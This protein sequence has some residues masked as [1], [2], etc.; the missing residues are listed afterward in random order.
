MSPDANMNPSE[1][2]PD[3]S[4]AVSPDAAGVLLLHRF[5][6]CAAS[7]PDA[8]AVEFR[9][10]QLTYA[11]LN[12]RANQVAHLLIDRGVIP[13]DLIA[14]CL[15]ASA[16]AIVAMLAVLKAGA[17]YVPID[18]RWPA[19]RVSG[20]VDQAGPKLVLTSQE[21]AASLCALIPQPVCIEALLA[22]A[23]ADAVS[24]DNPDVALNGNALCYVIYTSGTTG[25]P[26]GVMVS[27]KNIANLFSSLQEELHFSSRD[28]W[29]GLHSFAFGYSVW[30]IWGAL[31]S[32]AGLVIVP[33]DMRRDPGAWTQLAAA[34]G[35]SVLSLTPSALRQLLNL[36]PF[37]ADAMRRLVRLVVLS[38]EALEERDL[39][40]WF[41]HFSQTGPRLVNTFALTETAGR[42]ATSEYHQGKRP[43]ANS[44]GMPTQDAELFVVDPENLELSAE[45]E[46][47]VAGPM[48]AAG[49]LGNPELSA[50]RF[51]RF[52]P[53]DGRPRYCYRTGDVVRR[54]DS[55][56][57]QFAGR[58]DMQVKLR[59]HRVELSDIEH[60]LGRHPQIADAA[61]II[62]E[63]LS[64]TGRLSAFIVFKPDAQPAV[65]FWPS[66][67]EHLLY[68]ELLYDFMSA[69]EVR[70]EHYRAA[71]A[72]SV[73][74]KVVLDIGTG[75][76]AVLARM[77]A[78]AGARKVYAVELLEDACQ[79][80]RE[81]VADL[82]L[83]GQIEV[84][85]GD[86]QTVELPEQVD[87]CTQGVVGNIGSSDG[88]VPLWNA[89]RRWF[90]DD[91]AA[92]PARCTTLIAP[93]EL[94]A[95]VA[96]EPA[97]TSLA[98]DYLKRLFAEAGREFDARL[99]VR[100]F[101]AGNLLTDA[102]VF[103]ELD[104]GAGL[105]A[106]H[107]G[108]AEVPVH[109]QG[110]FDGFLL[111]T[112]L[113]NPGIEPVDFLEHQQAWLP[114]WLPVEDVGVPVE[115]GDRIAIDW[116][117]TTPD[118]SIFPD[119]MI[120]ADVYGAD[121]DSVHLSFSSPHQPTGVGQTTLHRAL[122]ANAPLAA[123]T[124]GADALRDWLSQEIPAYMVPASI[125]PIDRLPLNTSAKL[126]R[127]KL[128]QL[129]AAAV[130]RSPAEV[131]TA[132]DSFEAAIAEIWHSVL[133]RRMGRNED[134]FSSG[135]DS[136]LAVR[137]T[138]EIQRYLDDTIF[139]AALF[140]APTI[141]EYAQW[142]RAYHAEAV[143]RCVNATD[144]WE[145]GEL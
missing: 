61:V 141:A 134:F 87:V 60:A 45:G 98:A 12:A 3:V 129:A 10:G 101:P 21:N 86:M 105:V 40:Q 117:V 139:L 34:A 50:E 119:Y 54:L 114:V 37:P 133:G 57:L 69:D 110:R 115:P 22:A 120:S 84:I 5:E 8:L 70:I 15:S 14:L 36:E 64:G 83:D 18:A 55:G 81:L 52:D 106:A 125:Q 71:F 11:Q 43:A 137:L 58:M 93:G 126:D 131:E 30:E 9:G 132:D 42:I 75:R 33:E 123:S 99:C 38:G 19:G 122:Y 109:R 136:I 128:R 59:G 102:T 53:G 118:D 68:D 48:V 20:A 66:L 23:T 62:D 104:F 67:G 107:S 44:I 100:N 32:G 130:A 79:S 95:A 92:I 143:A 73:A 76:H 51:I 24:A 89:A 28:R 17:A 85:C 1:V 74:G 31:S 35:V 49:Y 80:A 142:L 113:S 145:E 16:D 127:D 144:D 94:P 29:L 41:E 108:R 6:A 91:F 96:G 111:W 65:E 90:N 103:E 138:T 77:C 112:R 124:P 39:D 82:G 135:G 78:A 26:N 56:A 4:S 7:C 63:P 121:K 13:G 27:H 97:F 140:D 25:K 2:L 46:L 47:L 72:G 88:I 116:T